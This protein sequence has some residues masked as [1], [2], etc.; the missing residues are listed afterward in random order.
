MGFKEISEKIESKKL[1][2]YKNGVLLFF[3]TC[4]IIC[5][6]DNSYYKIF[7][8]QVMINIQAVKTS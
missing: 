6:G 7:N 8:F 1:W 2:C 3:C 5:S 4:I